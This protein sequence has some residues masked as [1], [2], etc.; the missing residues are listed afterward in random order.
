MHRSYKAA[1]RRR[2]TLVGAP[3][4]LRN[5]TPDLE[6]TLVVSSYECFWIEDHDLILV[7]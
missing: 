2:A 1:H 7:V 4:K 3:R 6:P 5:W